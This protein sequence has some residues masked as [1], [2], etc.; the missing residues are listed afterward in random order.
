MPIHV[1]ILDDHIS[2]IDGYLYRLSKSPE[3]QVTATGTY[4]E[5]LEPMLARHAV[6]VLILDVSLPTSPENHNPFPV[7]HIIPRIFQQYPNLNILIV[8]ML[9]QHTLI[10]ALVD[11]GVSGYILKEDQ[12]SIQQLGKIITTIA[13]G[14]IYFSEAAYRKSPPSN[15][16]PVLT[17]RQLEA[18]SLCAAYPDGATILLA[19]RLGISGST[20]RNL[21]SGAYLRLG[22]RTRAAAIARASQLGLLPAPGQMSAGQDEAQE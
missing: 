13:A 5:E 9:N 21:L 8:S 3:I 15:I 11:I 14:G 2:I 6:D 19:H 16:K 10:E 1:A 4:G 17:S 7:L 22:V 18:L 12:A 20:L